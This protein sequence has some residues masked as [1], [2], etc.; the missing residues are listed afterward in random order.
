MPER[1]AVGPIFELNKSTIFSWNP[2]NKDCLPAHLIR[3]PLTPW[4]NYR[5]F[6]FTTITTKNKHAMFTHDCYLTVIREI[7]EIDTGSAGETFQFLSAR[8]QSASCTRK[9]E[10]DKLQTRLKPQC[11]P[12]SGR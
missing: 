5:P 12:H 6:L 9:V 10:H 1:I 7:M 8:R 11:N 3:L 2:I 4:P